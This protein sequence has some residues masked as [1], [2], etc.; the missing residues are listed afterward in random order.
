MNR[1]SLLA[2]AAVLGTTS[3]AGC[4][5]TFGMAEHEASP[6]SVDESARQDTGYEQTGVTEDTIEQSVDLAVFSQ[7]VSVTNY[8]TEHEKPIT[9]GPLTMDGGGGFLVVTTPQASVLGQELNPV[10]DMSPKELIERVEGNYAG[11][12]NVTHQEDGS[13][14]ILDQETTQSRFTAESSYNG[15]DVEVSIHI[16]EA[17]ETEEDL[18]VTVGVYPNERRDEEE[19]NIIS[20]MESVTEASPEDDGN[21]NESNDGGNENGSDGG[22]SGSDG[23]LL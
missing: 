4:L 19:S 18:L 14:T 7:E 10:S 9:V 6:A 12:E 15:S 22:E 21:Q 5:G 3:V 23:G 2:G 8:I 11:M 1:R 13:V 17:V 20:L 16:S